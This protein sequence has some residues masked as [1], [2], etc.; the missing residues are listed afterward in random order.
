M[1]QQV[2][3]MAKKRLPIA[4]ITKNWEKVNCFNRK[5]K[6]TCEQR[7]LRNRFLTVRS[8]LKTIP[9]QLQL[10]PR[11]LCSKKAPHLRM[12]IKNLPQT[13]RTSPKTTINLQYILILI[14]ICCLKKK[15]KILRMCWIVLPCN[16]MFNPR[17][18]KRLDKIFSLTLS[19]SIN[20]L[21]N[22]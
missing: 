16:I 9:P 5:K 1:K 6:K 14:K 8:I 11:W 18:K 15:S 7:L 17:F 13:N 20:L 22:V 2:S 21:H 3:I 19:K 4:N 12:N 10:T